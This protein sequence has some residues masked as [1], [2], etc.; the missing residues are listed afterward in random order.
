MSV[1][2]GRVLITSYPS[3]LSQLASALWAAVGGQPNVWL[4]FSAFRTAAL[5]VD[6][7]VSR[8][9]DHPGIN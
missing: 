5:V 6:A 3:D 9:A 1:T 4:V 7:T 8:G 2:T